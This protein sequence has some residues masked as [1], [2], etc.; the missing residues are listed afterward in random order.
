MHN[1]LPV[2][3][4]EGTNEVQSSSGLHSLRSLAVVVPSSVIIAC[5]IF[6]GNSMILGPTVSGSLTVVVRTLVGTSVVDD[7][8]FGF[9]SGVGPAIGQVAV[10][11]C[12]I[13]AVALLV[14]ELLINFF[15]EGLS[16]V[17]TDR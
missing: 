10:L 1:V 5:L 9:G 13:C 17:R 11:S 3:K 8:Q 7:G 12:E 16:E 14:L 6:V 4:N 15:D 2:H